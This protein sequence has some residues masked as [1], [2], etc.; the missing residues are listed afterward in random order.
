MIT[1]YVGDV[2]EYLSEVAIKADPNATLITTSM[3]DDIS[4]GTY[5][6]S[7]GDISD[8]SN[9]AKVLRQADLIV[10]APPDK[11]SDSFFGKSK[12]QSWTEDCLKDFAYFKP[13]ENLPDGLI[14]AIPE[15]KSIMLRLSGIRKTDQPQ[16]WVS[17]CSNTAGDGVNSNQ[18][19]GQL[20]A[21]RLNLP[22]SFLAES[23]SS[24]TWA[25]DQILRSD[26]IENDIL[27][28]GMTSVPRINYFQDNRIHHIFPSG[29]HFKNFQKFLVEHEEDILYKSL[30]SVY[31][32]INFCKKI[33][34]DLFLVDLLNLDLKYYLKDD[35]KVLCLGKL[36]GQ[37]MYEDFGYDGIH[38]GV[39]TH[40]FYAR[41]I[42]KKI[43]ERRR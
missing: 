32:V 7:V 19:Y 10:Y 15:N 23:G 26:L 28:W 5:Y 16:L 24:I 17:G 38:P 31:Q 41:E 25:A 34:V 18:R 33:K 12:M 11:W 43:Q 6:T 9:F 13:I 40:E 8:L 20:L 30:T 42:F 14:P 29:K 21:D 22:V 4:P 37:S 1:V 2:T 27:V 36:W 35:I 39:K 3:I